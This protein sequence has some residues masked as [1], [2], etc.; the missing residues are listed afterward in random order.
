MQPVAINWAAF[1]AAVVVRFVLGALWYSPLLFVRP[2]QAEAGQTDADM[3]ARMPKALPGELIGG[4][5]MAFVLVHAIR[6]AGADTAVLGAVV[7]VLNWLGFMVVPSVSAV[8]FGS[9][10]ARIALIDNGYNLAGLIAMGAIL[11]GWR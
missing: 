10:S 11:G 8:L 6:Y 9:R 1:A 7:G 5:V 3:K 2:W 4:A